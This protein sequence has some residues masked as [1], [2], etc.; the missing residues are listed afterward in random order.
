M[1]VLIVGLTKIKY[2][3]YLHFYL[4]RIS[5]GKHDVHILLWN[6]DGKEEP[7]PEGKLTYHMF[8]CLQQ[9]DVGKLLKLG[10]FW[11][12]RKYA[13]WVIRQEKPD[14]IIVLHSVPGV[15]ISDILFRQY[16][17]KYI[18]DYRD[19]TYESFAPFHATVNRLAEASRATFVSSDGFR[20]LL[21]KLDKVYTSHNL[22]TDSL[23]H[24]ERKNNAGKKVIR[25]GF[26]GMPRHEK[27]NRRM[28]RAL[29]GDGRFELHYYGRE[30]AICVRLKQYAGE[31]AANN[32]FFHGEYRPEDRYGFQSQ[33]DMLHNI[34]SN[35]E[36]PPSRLSMGNKYYDG[37]IFYLPQ[38]CMPGSYMG[39]RA[40][41]A[42]VGLCIDPCSQD[43]ADRVWEYYQ[44][45]DYSRFME[46]CD[47]EL[48]RILKE[49]HQSAQVIC[50]AL[51]QETV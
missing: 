38:I 4:D 21:P 20:S 32:V 42:G 8:H 37:I 29:A 17:G 51:E 36:L 11:K 25:I 34:Y 46:N 2:M 19:H 22:L 41:K 12:Y 9:D 31:L 49:Y 16:P 33:V 39:G 43:F 10:S 35:S 3:P 14:F 18:F 40:H 24:R 28:I 30:Q 23:S 27:L 15:L 13:A 47:R 7:M 48:D 50:Q 45:L 1:K 44:G 6:R 5:L 26:W